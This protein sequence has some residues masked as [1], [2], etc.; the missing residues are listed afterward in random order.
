MATLKQTLAAAIRIAGY[1]ATV[2]I[3]ALL[4]PRMMELGFRYENANIGLAILLVWFCLPIT[5][6]LAAFAGWFAVTIAHEIA[7]SGNDDTLRR[8]VVLAQS[9]SVLTTLGS[10]GMVASGIEPPAPFDAIYDLD[11]SGKYR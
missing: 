6:A 4:W 8:N 1:V 11:L 5:M 3:G 7:P 10:C 2:A 9:L